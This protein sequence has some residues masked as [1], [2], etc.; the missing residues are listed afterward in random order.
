MGIWVI[1]SLPLEN[2]QSSVE[3]ENNEPKTKLFQINTCAQEENSVCRV[4]ILMWQKLIQGPTK[5]LVS[6]VAKDMG[7]DSKSLWAQ[8][9]AFQEKTNAIQI[10]NCILQK[11]IHLEPQNGTLFGNMIVAD[12]IS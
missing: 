11:F 5:Q 10:L 7:N 8:S 9:L 12:V 2:L 4:M 3:R 1:I 6:S